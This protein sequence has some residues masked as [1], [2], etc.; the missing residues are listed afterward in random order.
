MLNKNV[1]LLWLT[2]DK[3]EGK[4]GWGENVEKRKVERISV[5]R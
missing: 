2:I 1:F 3:K 5:G 4:Q